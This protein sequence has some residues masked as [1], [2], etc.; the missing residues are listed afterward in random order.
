MTSRIFFYGLYMDTSLLEGMGF[1]PEKVGVS[2]LADYEI[3]IGERATLAPAPGRT[4]YGVLLDLTEKEASALYSRPE[5][6]DYQPKAVEAVL[7]SDDSQHSALCY[8]LPK[9]KLG[10]A[11]NTEYVC[12][13]S[14]LAGELGFPSDYVQDIARC[15]DD[16]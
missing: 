6:N 2:K 4:S 9:E 13:L 8:V 5:V 3:Q 15:G 10:A 12:K 1:R 14:A 11:T 16:T 7:L